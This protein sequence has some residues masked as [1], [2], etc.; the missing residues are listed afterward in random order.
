MNNG[1]SRYWITKDKVKIAYEDLE[2][3]HLDNIIKFLRR[4]SDKKIN[5]SLTALEAERQ[6]RCYKK[7]GLVR[8]VL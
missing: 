8:V 7:K 5:P 6:R 2:D 4:S 3:D 1:S